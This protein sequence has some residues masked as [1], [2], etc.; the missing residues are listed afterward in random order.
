MRFVRFIL[1]L[2]MTIPFSCVPTPVDVEA[3]L[4]LDELEDKSEYTGALVIDGR[5]YQGDPVDKIL[6]NGSPS[7]DD[8][9]LLLFAGYYSLEVFRQESRRSDPEV[10]RVVI[11]DPLRGETEWGLPPWTPVDPDTGHWVIR[12]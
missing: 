12:G 4:R 6:V 3:D 7:P 11:L 5:S 2:L 8:H 10:I 9:M 1:I